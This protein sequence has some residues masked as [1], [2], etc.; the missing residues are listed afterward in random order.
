MPSVFTL[1]IGPQRYAAP[2]QIARFVGNLAC[3][4]ARVRLS[5]RTRAAEECNPVATTHY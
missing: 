3:N 2:G 5:V 4:Q 1:Q